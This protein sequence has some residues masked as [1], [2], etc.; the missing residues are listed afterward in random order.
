MRAAR[1]LRRAAHRMRPPTASTPST[2]ALVQG[3]PPSGADRGADEACK[4][5]SLGRRERGAF[6]VFDRADEVVSGVREGFHDL[7]VGLG[8][9]RN[10][11]VV[12]V[13]LDLATL[14]EVAALAWS[15]ANMARV[16]A[17]WSRS[18]IQR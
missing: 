5:G 4:R 18:S 11:E 6:A 9:I 17:Q 8:A 3:L 10:V 13:D 7:T 2:V 1:A 15:M 14:R 16:V 12:D